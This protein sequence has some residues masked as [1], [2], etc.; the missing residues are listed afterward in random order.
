V[1]GGPDG[2]LL[3]AAAISAMALPLFL[4]HRKLA[5]HETMLVRP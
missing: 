2:A 4:L 1:R 5:H 3:A